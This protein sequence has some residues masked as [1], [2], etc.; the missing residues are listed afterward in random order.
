MTWE[1]TLIVL[2]AWL[3]CK[4]T[5]RQHQPVEQRSSKIEKL[6]ESAQFE[7]R[8][9]ERVGRHGE[10]QEPDEPVRRNSGDRASRHEGRECDLTG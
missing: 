7:M 4:G 9:L 2:Y 10:P 1:E 6:P 8:R 3:T 5:Y